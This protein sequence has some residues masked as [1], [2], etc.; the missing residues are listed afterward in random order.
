MNT[1][2]KSSDEWK[3]KIRIHLQNKETIKRPPPKG[4]PNN[5]L[6]DNLKTVT[7][8]KTTNPDLFYAIPNKVLM[9]KLSATAKG[10]YAV[11]CCL[12]DFKEEN[13]FQV[14]IENIGTYAGLSDWTTIKKAL[15]ELR[16][17]NIIKANKVRKQRR[18][19][20][21]DVEFYRKEDLKNREYHEWFPFHSCIVKSGAWAKLNSKSQALYLTLRIHSNFEYEIEDRETYINQFK[22]RDSETYF[23]TWK[24]VSVRSG[25]SYDYLKTALRPLEYL[26]LVAR[27]EETNNCFLEVYFRPLQDES[28]IFLR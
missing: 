4:V 17:L 23:S 16:G 6:Y 11:L 12:S 19:W 7:F 14:S 22:H 18:Y 20:I 27:N 2:K 5:K 28:G 9:N 3:R 15:D 25:V 21:Y 13:E 10:V 1:S 8:D 24:E 26:G